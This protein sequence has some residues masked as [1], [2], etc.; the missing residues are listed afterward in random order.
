MGFTT[1][2]VTALHEPSRPIP[3]VNEGPFLDFSEHAME[4]KMFS[5]DD[6]KDD[7]LNFNTVITLYYAVWLAM[8]CWTILILWSIRKQGPWIHEMLSEVAARSDTAAG[9][10]GELNGEASDEEDGGR[11]TDASM[12]LAKDLNEVLLPNGR[13]P[14][15]SSCRNEARSAFS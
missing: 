5:H 2:F 7:W 11:G 15:C 13:G 10:S 6:R 3:S 9:V 1:C 14:D 12:N 8:M 4:P